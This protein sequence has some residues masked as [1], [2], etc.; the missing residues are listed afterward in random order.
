[1]TDDCFKYKRKALVVSGLGTFI[2]TLDTSI[3]N[4]SLPTI[5]R[6]L[7]TSVDIVGWVVLA[8]G[9]TLFS[10]LMIFGALAEKKGYQFS[11]KY[12]FAAFLLGS[13]LCGLSLNI[14][15][16]IA[17][18]VIQ[19]LGA[20]LLISV[21]P[22]MITHS[23]PRS[24]RGRG[25]SI[26]A[27]VVA[28][29]LMLGPP[30]GGFIIGLGGWRWIFFVNIP[31][32]IIGIYF[33]NRFIADFPV[34]DP[35][36]KISLPGAGSLSLGLLLMMATLLLFSRQTLTLS[37]SII[38]LLISCLLFALFFYFESKP[39]TR[40]IGIDILKNR[41]FALS[42]IAMLLVFIALIS[43]TI[44]IPFYLEQI[45]NLKP[46]QV[47][48]FLMIIPV[49]NFFLSPVAGYLSDRIQTRLISSFGIGLMMIG[50]FMIKGFNQHTSFTDIALPILILGIGMAFFTTPNTSTIMGSVEK[51]QLGSASGILATIRTL[52]ISLGVGLSIAVFSFYR[53]SYPGE[54]LNGVEGFIYGYQSVY[55]IIIFVII[56]AAVFSLARG[57]NLCVGKHD[58]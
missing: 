15:F 42:G 27:M 23:F 25:L 40:F 54:N 52:G 41:V 7:E 1:V 33:T 18:R 20:A 17:S 10:L 12:G 53:N 4:V 37:Y 50:I 34:S 29:G 21:G 28:T 30:L 35:N 19:G 48:F 13:I 39:Q 49:C 5:S 57:K 45:K 38:L 6:E 44:L 9:I 36:K 22:A 26:I 46:Q 14:Y 47:G 24:E 16:L 58:L 51:F 2:G 11:Y 56:L 32:C 55:N 3:V 31:V 43:V 8:Y